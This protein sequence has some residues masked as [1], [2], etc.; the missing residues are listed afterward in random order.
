MHRLSAPI[1]AKRRTRGVSKRKTQNANA[2]KT[3]N[4]KTRKNAVGGKA[5]LVSRAVDAV[6]E[7]AER[8]RDAPRVTQVR[9][10][11]DVLRTEK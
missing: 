1:N 5:Q 11:A 9:Q 2:L 8:C 3:Q 6:Q 4:A 10:V 7:H